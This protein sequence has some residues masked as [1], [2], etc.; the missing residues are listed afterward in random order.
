MQF[1]NPVTADNGL[2]GAGLVGET[3]LL[4][5]LSINTGGG[6]GAFG[7]T[8][9]T[10]QIWNWG[11]SPLSSPTSGK[12]QLICWNG[13]STTASD[14]IAWQEGASNRMAGV[15]AI[16]TDID[17]PFSDTGDPGVFL[18]ANFMNVNCIFD[19]FYSI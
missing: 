15:T 6:H 19:V 4:A 11:V 12:A 18:I 3:I 5:S 2:S 14:V 8:S 9:G 13:V 1:G 17:D 16:A 7:P 10:I